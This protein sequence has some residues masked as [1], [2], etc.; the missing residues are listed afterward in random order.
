[1]VQARTAMK[2]TSLPNRSP[3]SAAAYYPVTVVKSVQPSA[4]SFFLEADR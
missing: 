4:I 2:V 3:V 1:M